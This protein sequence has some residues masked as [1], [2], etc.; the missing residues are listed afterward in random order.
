ML[1]PVGEAHALAEELRRA[2]A[3][4][5]APGSPRPFFDKL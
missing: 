4:P 3:Q 5:A 1:W 2:A